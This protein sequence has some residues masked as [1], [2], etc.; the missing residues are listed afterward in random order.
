MPI[1]RQIN[2]PPR[3]S[4][5]ECRAVEQSVRHDHAVEEK[6]A[7]LVRYAI[8]CGSAT[9]RSFINSMK[10]HVLGQ[11]RILRIDEGVPLRPYQA[12][13]EGFFAAGCCFSSADLAL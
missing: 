12:E 10:V 8:P 11:E 5:Q 7:K 3:G 4:L 9:N 1:D 2:L 6:P 13:A